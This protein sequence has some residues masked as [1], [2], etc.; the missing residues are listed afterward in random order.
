MKNIKK[1]TLAIVAVFVLSTGY[2]QVSKD[3][4]KEVNLIKMTDAGVAIVGTDDAL[5]GIDKNGRELWKNVKLRKVE[6]ERVEVLSGSELVFISDK[7][8][9]RNRVLNVLNGK[10]YAN[11]EA[12]YISAARVAHG[13]NQLWVLV[14]KA[15]QV[16]DINSNEKLYQLDGLLDGHI[17]TNE[18][19]KYTATFSGM[20]PITYTSNESAIIHLG[21]G[22]LAEYNLLTGDIK[23]AVDWKPYK[24]KLD[25][26][27]TD[28]NVSKR[29]AVM[30]LDNDV[31]YFPFRDMLLAVDAK[32]GSF[33][34]DTKSKGNRVGKVMDMYVV[35][36]G[37][38]VLTDKG[39]QLLDKN[40][41]AAKWKKPL[42][43]KEAFSSILLKDGD[44]IYAISKTSLLK[45]DVAN[46]QTEVLTEKIKL[47]SKGD[48]SSLEVFGDKIVIGSEQEVVGIDKKS[49]KIDFNTYYK[50]PGAGI[51]TIAGNIVLAG[52]AM[53]ATMNSYNTNSN[54]GN[55][56]YYQYTPALM[57]N[58]G[59]NTVDNGKFTY[60]STKFN[61]S[62]AKGFGLA[63]VDKST[64]ETLDKIVVGD[65]NPVYDVDD[66]RGVI[67]FKSGGKSIQVKEIK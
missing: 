33:K 13:T 41:G 44:D 35:D 25:N 28:S 10:D 43:I 47:A 65:R 61:E 31:L 8:I 50:A 15:I 14:N 26:G 4:P 45:I 30:K 49:G 9:G 16:W 51:A 42:K 20:Q 39:L 46:Q 24:V 38:L 34:W 7:G 29:F 11:P 6:A 40:S 56:T 27:D 54:A 63:R 59:S 18:G 57:S 17:G 22:S 58:G 3:F 19:A 23:W 12:N 67:F 2:S 52:V 21:L 66:R 64:G 55:R 48:F 32:N 1:F 36:Q 62:A 53:A 60:V 5:Y 37:V